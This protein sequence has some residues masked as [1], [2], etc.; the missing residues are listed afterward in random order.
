[1]K[2]VMASESDLSQWKDDKPIFTSPA[3]WKN[4]SSALYTTWDWVPS[5]GYPVMPSSNGGEHNQISGSPLTTVKTSNDGEGHDVSQSEPQLSAPEIQPQQEE[6]VLPVLEEN[7]KADSLASPKSQHQGDKAAESGLSSGVSGSPNKENS[8]V[9][10]QSPLI[11]T[12]RTHSPEGDH[13]TR[14]S[15]K[16]ESDNAT[17]NIN[18]NDVLIS[19]HPSAET[20]S[21]TPGDHNTSQNSSHAALDTNI[22]EGS[23]ETN[24]TIPASTTNTVS[25]ATTTTSIPSVPNSEIKT[26]AST[27]QNKP[28]VDS[29]VSPVWIRT[30]APL[31]IVAVLVSVTVY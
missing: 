10:T 11:T 26:I 27:V 6:V 12:T 9:E 4:K 24:S 22:K 15:P 13:S 2:A 17:G 25:E 20:E 28:I 30:A 21:T 8:S 31:L 14:S 29:S 16:G 23:Q 18:N 7:S 19:Q 5:N 1:P 3:K